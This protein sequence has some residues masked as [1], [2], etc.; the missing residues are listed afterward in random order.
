MSM[1]IGFI[2][3]GNM[4]FPLAQHLILKGF[5]LKVFNRNPK[6]TSLLVKQGAQRVS[7][8]SDV[9]DNGQIVITMLSDDQALEQIAL[10]TDDLARR[11]GPGGIHLSMS[12]VSPQTARKIAQQHQLF[13]VSYLAAPVFGRP[14]AAKARKLWICLSGSQA[15]K[16]RARP[17]LEVLGQGIYDFGEDVGAANVVKL[18]GN[19]LIIS[20]LEA[21]SEMLTLAEKNGIARAQIMDFISQTLFACPI[22]QNYGKALIQELYEPAAFRMALALKDIDLVLQT[23]SESRTPMPLANLAHDRMVSGIAKGRGNMDMIAIAKS[24]REDAGL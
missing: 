5:K 23:A 8:A 2:G 3:T 16:D 4:G 19:F 11:L 20:A 7:N 17:I 1:L 12:T 6:K 15:A 14:E 13:G 24:I 9:A 10:A 18:A 21:M 22:Y